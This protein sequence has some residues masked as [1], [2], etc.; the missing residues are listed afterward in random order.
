MWH[1]GAFASGTAGSR[2]RRVVDSFP[3]GV[4]GVSIWES[5]KITLSSTVSHLIEWTS[6]APPSVEEENGNVV[7]GIDN[8]VDP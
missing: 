6:Q 5:W 8:V 4:F 2:P 1:G 7:R 3:T